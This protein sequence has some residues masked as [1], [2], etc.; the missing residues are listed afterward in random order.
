MTNGETAEQLLNRGAL[1]EAV[2]AFRK[3][4][5]TNPT[6]ER[7]LGLAE[8]FTRLQKND[9]RLDAI[10]QALALAP[11]SI[12]ALIAKGDAYHD[13]DNRR[14]AGAFYAHGLSLAQARQQAGQHLDRPLLTLLERGQRR[15]QDYASRY[16]G[17]LIEQLS[18]NV[19]TGARPRRFER[20]L[21][22]MFG[23]Q[24]IY[25]QQP[26]QYYF[27]ELPATP[28]YETSHFSWV[29]DLEA[30]WKTILE[31][32]Q[33][34]MVQ[35]D[36]GTLNKACFE[37]YVQRNTDSP[38]T[39]HSGMMDNPGW[40]AIFLWRDG[41]PVVETQSVFPRTTALLE[42]ITMADI[43]GNSPTALFSLLKAGTEIP[44]HNGLINTRLICHLPLIIPEGCGLRVGPETRSW[45]PGSVMIFDD[46][47]EHTAWNRSAEDRIILLFDTPN[48]HLN[49]GEHDA[50]RDLFRAIHDF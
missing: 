39:D 24:E 25:P 4:I 37:P 36:D 20:S 50:V 23:E 45:T 32:V 6:P 10:S 40:S 38:R 19:E 33:A 46:T 21:R 11:T 35:I 31:E 14:Q 1:E 7:W 2:V 3:A 12:E 13:M 30:E 16:K 22:L 34:V 47:I 43:P 15:C 42:K 48:P 8:A 49:E 9:A 18:S 5:D 28:F 17:Y 44:P 26:T 29:S 41:N 27:P